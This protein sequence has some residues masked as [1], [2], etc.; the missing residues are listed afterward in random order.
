MGALQQVLAAGGAKPIAFVQQAVGTTA[1]GRD[2]NATLSSA[3]GANV[4]IIACI[5][6]L[7]TATVTVPPAFNAVTMTQVVGALSTTTGVT[8]D[9][10]YLHGVTGGTE[11]H[12]ELDL[13]VRASVN[14]SE[15]TG[16]ANAVEQ[17]VSTGRG[18]STSMSIVP[19]TQDPTSVSN[20]VVGIGAYSNATSAY[21][22]GP[23]NSFT[24]LTTTG[25][26]SVF[27]EAG[28]LIRTTD[29]SAVTSVVTLGSSLTW[30]GCSASF[31]G[32]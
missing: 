11:L 13:I 8:T 14:V 22:S 5:S 18:T 26:A 15:W 21:S 19:A 2:T 29:H 1:D 4:T 24:R 25:G 31:G 6:Y 27:Q 3:A 23:S 20:L 30:A 28:Y 32:S 16:I 12:Y 7:D 17:D 9:I 10:Y